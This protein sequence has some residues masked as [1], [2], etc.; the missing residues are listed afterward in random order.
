[1]S[2][3]ALWYTT[4]ATGL[5][6]LLLLTCSMVVGLMTA[7]R[8]STRTWPGF[9]QQDLHRR[10]ALISVIFLAIHVLTSVLDTYVSIGILSAVV[11]FT[12]HYDR[13]W[14][15]IGTIGVDSMLAVV[16]SSLLR[17]RI[18]AGVWRALHWL[19]YLC[20]PVALAHAFGMGT[21]MSEP[22]AIG[23][24]VG[25]VAAVLTAGTT[26]LVLLNRAFRAAPVLAGA[27]SWPR[28]SSKQRAS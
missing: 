10:V 1:M 27:G 24:G 8:F 17:Q 19:A 2:S 3:T 26:R 23:L 25:C 12:S 13:A 4:R 14:V 15:A 11:P 5:V 20:W 18:P 28:G 21:D 22:W 7:G 6:A 9:A 16:A